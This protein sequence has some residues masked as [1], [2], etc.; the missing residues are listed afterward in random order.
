QNQQLR[1]AV[2]QI[3]NNC[4][5]SQYELFKIAQSKGYYKPAE[6]AD[7]QQIQQV[8]SQLQG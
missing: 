2:Q 4:E 5:N 8:K 1:S 7:S 3:R 6:Q